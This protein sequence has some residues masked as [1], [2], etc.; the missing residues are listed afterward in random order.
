M[1]NFFKK[2]GVFF[3]TFVILFNNN[4]FAEGPSIQIIWGNTIKIISSK[5]K[6]STKLV[7]RT[8]VFNFLWWYVIKSDLPKS[9]KYIDLKFLDVNKNTKLYRSLQKLVYLDVIENKSI[10]IWKKKN[11]N[12][13]Y[14]YKLVEKIIWIN[15]VKW[16]SIDKLKN[17]KTNVW[18]L[19]KVFN[20]IKDLESSAKW[21]I[22][23]NTNKESYD[24]RK[25]FLILM[26][27]YKTLNNGHYDKNNLDK[28]KLVEWAISWLAKATKDKF[29]TYFPPVENKWFFEELNWSFEWIWAY[30]DLEQPWELKIV[31]PISW[32]PAEKSGLKG[33]D[34][35]YKVWDIELTKEMSLSEIVSYIK[36]PAWTKV[37]LYIKRWKEKLEIEVTRAKITIKD[38]EW[39]KLGYNTYYI[40]LKMFWSKVAEQFDEELEKIK[41][42]RNIKKIIIDVR[43]NP[44]WF[45]DKVSDVLSNFVPKWENVAVVKYLKWS[46]DYRSSWKNIIDFNK[47]KIILLQNSWSASASEILVWT[48]KDYYPDATIIWETSYWKGSVQTIKSYYDGSSLKYTIAKWYT[49]KTETWIDHVWIK[50]DIEIKL[51]EKRFSNWYDNQ[52]EKAKSIR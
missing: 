46:K 45:L 41:N 22:N 40:Q 24:V 35:I 23:L 26:D 34:I 36:W 19:K 42:D 48:I 2:L 17:T 38:V 14:Y 44:G 11:I 16:E 21:N 49:W 15:L 20:T 18:D 10:S 32:S 3:I 52:L 47:Y 1:Y 28:I 12:R 25:K 9:Y 37:K 51:D 31:S 5:D 27:V 33:W 8:D 13:Y 29:T 7:N 43:N 6:I 39:K 30:V 50:P 4:T